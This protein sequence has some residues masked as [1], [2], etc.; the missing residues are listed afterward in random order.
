MPG[1]IGNPMGTI[2]RNDGGYPIQIGTFQVIGLQVN[3]EISQ[4]NWMPTFNCSTITTLQQMTFIHTETSFLNTLL[5]IINSLFN[6]NDVVSP[7]K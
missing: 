6:K 7:Q 4:G 5:E 2:N 1:F 3:D